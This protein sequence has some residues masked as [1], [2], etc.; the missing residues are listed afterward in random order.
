MDM[1]L[2]KYIFKIGFPNFSN[3]CCWYTL[4]LPQRKLQCAPTTY[5]HSINECLH[6]KQVFLLFMVQCIEHV[7]M[8]KVFEYSSSACTWMTLIDSQFYVTGS[9]Y[10]DVS[11]E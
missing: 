10:L 4:E 7:E 1:I 8:N 9:L 2:V 5:V 3:I 6:K 11:S